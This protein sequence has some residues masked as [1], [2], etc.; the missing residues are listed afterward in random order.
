[1]QADQ[2]WQTALGRIELKLKREDYETWLSD[3]EGLS[4][5]DGTLI[6]G[7]RSAYA[8][9]WL[10]PPYGDT[11]TIVSDVGRS[12]PAGL[13]WSRSTASYGA[14]L[15]WLLAATGRAPDSGF[16]RA[17][18]EQAALTTFRGAQHVW[19]TGAVMVVRELQQPPT[20]RSLL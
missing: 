12:Q 1:M 18:P 2:L 11:I 14:M 5:E 3:S 10:E 16:Q 19:R 8:K 13:S 20:N 4:Y 7:V 6:V 15:G 9:D 17:E